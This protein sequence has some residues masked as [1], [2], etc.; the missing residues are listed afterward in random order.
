M[1]ALTKEDFIKTGALLQ[2]HFLL[3]SGLHSEQYLQCALLLA[4]PARAEAIGAE[5]AALQKAKP[6]LILSPAMGGLII[7]Q[8][9]ARALK[10][11][12]FFA[13]REN[14]V[15]TLRR[16]FCLKPGEKVLIVEDVITTGKSSREVMDLAR[17]QG[18][19][20]AAAASIVCRAAQPPELGV[21]T[22]SLL[23]IEVANY[24]ADQCP[25]C[26]RGLPLLKPGSRTTRQP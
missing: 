11:R 26:R 15:M 20:V 10:I 14:G 12:H 8:E 17:S 19:V 3:S 21:P 25:F 2:G 7:G 16:G 9:V 22:T 13:E 23:N 4:E 5:L 1:S 24:P 18:A 6:D